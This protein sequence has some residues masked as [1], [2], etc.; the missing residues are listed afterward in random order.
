MAS[1]LH[2]RVPS[3]TSTPRPSA[4][5]AAWPGG[6][7][8][9][10][11]TSP[12]ATRRCRW[13]ARRCA[14]PGLSG[15]DHENVPWVNHLV[16]AVRAGVGLE[17]GV[18]TPGLGRPAPRRGPRPADP[19]PEVRQRRGHLPPPRGQGRHREPQGRAH[20]GRPRHPRRSTAS[21]PPATAW[22]K[23][24][25]RP[26]AEAVDLPHRRHRQHLR[27]HPAGPAGRPRGRRRHR[28]HPLH[29]RRACSTTCPR[30]PPARASAAPTP[31][32]RT[33]ASCGPRSTSRARSSAATCASPTTPAAC[34]C[35]R[36]P[37]WPA[38]SGST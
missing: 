38:S 33:S 7:G 12:A 3:S 6:P 5:P 20:V 21:A 26:E 32:R 18:T 37:R 28:R 31:P 13:S 34:A 35:P 17:H 16:D 10:W 30:A 8:S 36:S 11:S 9:R 24:L 22:C 4:A 14:W 2:V 23:P 27:G 29:R 1:C 15:A 25:R 19:R